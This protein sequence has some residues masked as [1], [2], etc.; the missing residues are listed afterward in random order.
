MFSK[1]AIRVLEKRY[2]LKNDNGE[3]VETPQE[4]VERV[5]QCVSEADK[6]YGVSGQ[7]VEALKR[8]YIELM[9]K[10]KFLPNSPTLMNAGRDGG[11]LSACFVLLFRIILKEYLKPASMPP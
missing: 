4:M 7:E 2:L 5:A 1:N 9:E 8:S 3:L 11:Q 6:K 10:G